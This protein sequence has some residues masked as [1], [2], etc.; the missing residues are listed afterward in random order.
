MSQKINLHPV[1]LHKWKVAGG[2]KQLLATYTNISQIFAL[3]LGG[4]TDRDIH[5][6]QDPSSDRRYILEKKEPFGW[7]RDFKTRQ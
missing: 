4:Y 7:I 6:G 3:A 2:K 1:Y 5:C